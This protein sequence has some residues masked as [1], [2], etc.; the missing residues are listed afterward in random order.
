MLAMVIA[1]TLA[2]SDPGAATSP[3]AQGATVQ[4]AANPA[5]AKADARKSRSEQMI[6]K[7]VQV[8]GI[9]TT[10]KAC[11]TQREWDDHQFWEQQDLRERQAGLCGVGGGC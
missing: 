11:A 10:R 7:T 9:G 5:Q 6:C 4:A 2:A 1:A 8:P 3:A